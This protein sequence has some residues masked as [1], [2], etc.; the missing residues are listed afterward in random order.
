MLAPQV[1]L[2]LSPI[3]KHLGYG[4]PLNDRPKSNCLIDSEVATTP[5]V[6]SLVTPILR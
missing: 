6:K 4:R 1:S 5:K 3:L 2:L